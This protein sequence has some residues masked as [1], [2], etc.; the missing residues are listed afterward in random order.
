MNTTTNMKFDNLVNSILNEEEDPSE[1]NSKYYNDRPSGG[2]DTVEDFEFDFQDRHYMA[3]VVYDIENIVHPGDRDTPDYYDAK[4]NELKV[5]QLWIENEDGEYV[6]F[7]REQNPQLWDAVAK[8][9]E[10]SFYEN[11]SNWNPDY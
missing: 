7:K 4:V 2:S 5:V 10:D 6:D 11:E 1:Y 9:G 8:A 3:E